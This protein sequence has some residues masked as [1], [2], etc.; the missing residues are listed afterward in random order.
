VTTFLQH[1]LSDLRGG[2]HSWRVVTTLCVPSF[3]LS[4]AT[5]ILQNA[6]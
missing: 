3:A 5:Y 1:T 2:R 4:V 6:R